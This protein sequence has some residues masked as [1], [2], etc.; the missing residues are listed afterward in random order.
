MIA[1][2]ENDNA[3]ISKTMY[4]SQTKLPTDLNHYESHPAV[5]VYLTRAR[6]LYMTL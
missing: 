3:R 4:F 6:L 2:S 5:L 1:G